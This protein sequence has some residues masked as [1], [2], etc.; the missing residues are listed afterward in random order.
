M[1]PLRNFFSMAS[2]RRGHKGTCVSKADGRDL[3]MQLS[4]AS[5]K[6]GS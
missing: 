6:E 5:V 3:A 2:I 4:Q 1:G